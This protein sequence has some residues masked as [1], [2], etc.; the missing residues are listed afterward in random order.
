M[1][2]G[3]A[4]S[5]RDVDRQGLPRRKARHGNSRQLGRIFHIL[6]KCQSPTG[7]RLKE[8]ATNKRHRHLNVKIVRRTCSERSPY[9]LP[10]QTQKKVR[11]VEGSRIQGTSVAPSE[12]PRAKAD[13]A[14]ETTIRKA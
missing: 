11:A 12:T 14:T 2:E 7:V 3:Y 6:D 10:F 8:G 4:Y 1:N 9:Q 5:L 13:S